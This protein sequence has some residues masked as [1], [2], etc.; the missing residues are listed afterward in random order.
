M[1]KMTFAEYCEIVINYKILKD[2]EALQKKAGDYYSGE[3]KR[4]SDLY[5]KTDEVLEGIERSIYH[6]PNGSDYVSKEHF[7]EAM[8]ILKSVGA[9]WE[10]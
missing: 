6:R 3:Q 9:V 2:I 1:R 5:S 10:K 8:D 4:L 7:A